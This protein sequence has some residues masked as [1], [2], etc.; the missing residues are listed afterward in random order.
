MHNSFTHT[1]TLITHSHFRSIF[2]ECQKVQAMGFKFKSK[3][4][5]FSYV[6]S[7]AAQLRVCMY[8][9]TYMCMYVCVYVCTLSVPKKPYACD[10]RTN[11]FTYIPTYTHTHTHA[12][13]HTYTQ[14]YPGP[15]VLTGPWLLE[16]VRT[17]FNVFMHVCMYVWC[18]CVHACMYVSMLCVNVV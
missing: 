15:K 2:S 1:I 3:E 18:M 13:I 9:C 11:T 8:V 14:K 12:C 10:S 7:L 17:I 4:R 6:S 16:E 5:P